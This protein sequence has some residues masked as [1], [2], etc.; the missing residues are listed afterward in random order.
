MRTDANHAVKFEQPL[1][2]KVMTLDGTWCDQGFLIDISDGEAEIRL[3]GR[4]AELSEFFLVL[5]NFGKPVFRLCKREWVH[6]AKI[7][8]SFKKTKFGIDS[9]KEMHMKANEHSSG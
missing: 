9:L 7:G 8:V 1:E 3:V 6:G 4:S 2:V 5:T